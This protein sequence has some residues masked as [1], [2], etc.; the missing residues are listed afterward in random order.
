[1]NTF[2]QILRGVLFLVLAICGMAMA[3]I[4]MVS[5]AIAIGVLYIVARIKGRPFGVRAY[6]DSRQPSARSASFRKDDVV[7]V[8]MREIP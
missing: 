1:M 8:K 3:F 4:F 2:T 7:D 6:W 5:T